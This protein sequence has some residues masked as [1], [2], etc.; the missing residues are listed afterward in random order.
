MSDSTYTLTFASEDGTKQ[1][2]VGGK[3]P[4]WVS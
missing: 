2:L 4:T 1:G 3:V